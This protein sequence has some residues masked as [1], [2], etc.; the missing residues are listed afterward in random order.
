MVDA[1]RVANVL[2][3]IRIR[4]QDLPTNG[5]PTIRILKVTSGCATRLS[6]NSRG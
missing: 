6:T 4:K 1:Y 5:F 3:H 2:V